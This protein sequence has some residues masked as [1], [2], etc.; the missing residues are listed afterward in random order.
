MSVRKKVYTKPEIVD[1]AL[2]DA[3]L[4]ISYNS[5]GNRDVYDHAG[6]L[7]FEIPGNVTNTVVVAVAC[8]YMAGV[9]EGQR[10]KAYEIR[11]ALTC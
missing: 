4:R 5:A 9:K 3:W 1:A 2:Q 11:A 6:N 10:R 8:A 7:A